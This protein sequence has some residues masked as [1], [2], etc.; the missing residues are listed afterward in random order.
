MW[1]WRTLFIVL[2]SATVLVYFGYR[3]YTLTKGMHSNKVNAL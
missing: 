1:T 3:E 2:N